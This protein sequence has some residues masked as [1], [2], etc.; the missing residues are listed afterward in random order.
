MT[1]LP[2][3]GDHGG[4]ARSVAAALGLAPSS[5]LDLSLSLNP[6]APPIEPLL[7]RH[8]AA[9]RAYP[10]P[11][12]ATAALAEVL[13]VDRRCLLLTN[14][15]AESIA[16][17]GSEVGTGWVEAPDFSLYARSLAAL[18]PAGP[19]FR[20]NPNNPTGRLAG[21]SDRADVWDEAFYSLATGRWTRGDAAAGA[22]VLGSLT[23]L[24]ACPGLRVG[25][26]LAADVDL[27]AR[28]A[29][30]Q[31]RWSVNGLAAAVL[32]DLLEAADLAGWAAATADLRR[33][34]VGILCSAGF[35][36]EPSDANFVLLHAPGLR[37]R[38]A[39][40]GIVVRDCASFGLPEHVRIAVPAEPGL[41][42]LARALEEGG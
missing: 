17:V 26:V 21:P 13:G 30:R 23:K 35:E 12:T 14:G 11:S 2:P 37:A 19:R 15:G 34:L 10:D 33:S 31:P 1:R 27:M 32:P 18:D 42:R 28:L 25:F 8:L 41:V 3:P 20:S 9:A 29:R 24:F 38:L 5:M 16:L 39:P 40:A 7:Q 36:P 4:D 6:V 22:V